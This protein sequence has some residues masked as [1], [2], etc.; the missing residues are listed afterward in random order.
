MG[1]ACVRRSVAFKDF[2]FVPRVGFWRMRRTTAG[3]S[4]RAFSDAGVC[5]PKGSSIHCDLLLTFLSLL[6]LS[7]NNFPQACRANMTT[8]FWKAPNIFAIRC[9]FF[10][11]DCDA[12]VCQGDSLLSALHERHRSLQDA[13]ADGGESAFAVVSCY[14]FRLHR[15]HTERSLSRY[16]RKSEN[17]NW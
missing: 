6:S 16:A 3:E 8:W 9:S 17:Q 13:L 2:P 12:S 7:A 14:P 15:A 1:A 5:V 4:E 10:V 11:R